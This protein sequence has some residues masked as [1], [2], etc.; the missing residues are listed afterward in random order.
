[1]KPKVSFLIPTKNRAKYIKDCLDSLID[2]EVKEWEAIVVNDHGNDETKKI[3]DNMSDERIKFFELN[4]YHGYGVSC[5]RNFAALNARADLIA[6]ADSD[7]I[8]YPN[9][10]TVTLKAF[11]EEPTADIFYAHLDVWEEEKNLIRERKTPFTP[12]NLEVYKKKNYIPHVTIAMKRKIL[13]DN[14][15]NSFFRVAEDYELISRLAVSGKKFIYKNIKVVKYRIGKQN[16]SIGGQ[17]EGLVKK[18]GSLVG[19][20]RG[21]QPF[22][23]TILGRIDA[24][25]K[26][27]K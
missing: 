23:K 14:P 19:M 13:L 4:D 9:R 1:M 7:D 5:A 12:F 17:N 21:W 6:V 22:D 25:E 24:M 18:Y 10:L 16:I 20:V 15:Y 2:Q 3:V 26:G 11:E 27:K 8:N